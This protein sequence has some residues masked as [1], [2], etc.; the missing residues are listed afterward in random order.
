MTES[1]IIVQVYPKA[2]G[3]VGI[4]RPKVTIRRAV[5]PCEIIADNGV[6]IIQDAFVIDSPAFS[7][8]LLKAT[9][10]FSWVKVP[11]K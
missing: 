7:R 8:E 11:R 10:L 9:V 6:C 4:I 1:N 2:D 5:G 3:W